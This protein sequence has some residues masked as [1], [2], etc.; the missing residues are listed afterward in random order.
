VGRLIP[1]PVGVSADAGTVKA[2]FEEVSLQVTRPSDVYPLLADVQIVDVREP[3]EWDAGH[4][5]GAVHVPLQSLLSGGEKGRLDPSR[6]VVAVCRSGNRSDLATAMLRAR[7]Y[8]AENME[9]GME[10]WE[11]DGLPFESSDGGTPRVA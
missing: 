7:G 4:I 5:A 11:R 10:E 3:Y 1:R 6:R 9:G 8:D 2:P